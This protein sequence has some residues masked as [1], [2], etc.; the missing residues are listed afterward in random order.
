VLAA[1][2][3]AR[4]DDPGLLGQRRLGKIL[5]FLIERELRFGLPITGLGLEPRQRTCDLFAVGNGAGRRRAH[6]D[7]GVFHLLDHEAYELLG[8][9]GLVEDGVDVRIHDIGKAGEDAHGR[10]LCL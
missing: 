8:V 4:I 6:L 1:Q 10:V 2:S 5:A 7:Q 9:L 3:I